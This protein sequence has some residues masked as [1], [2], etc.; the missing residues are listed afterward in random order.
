MLVNC[1]LLV[2]VH[3]LP[4]VF[5]CLAGQCP[6]WGLYEPCKR[7][8]LALHHFFVA[9]LFQALHQT[10]GKTLVLLLRKA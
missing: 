1:L 9:A 10:L 5:L 4:A 8:P 7:L 6:A 2:L 3:E